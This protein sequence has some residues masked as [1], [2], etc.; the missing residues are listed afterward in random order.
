MKRLC[1]VW[2]CFLCVVLPA[3]QLP[4]Q[5]ELREAFANPPKSASPRVWW[6]WMNG[7]ISPEGIRKDL[8]WM[9]SAGVAGFHMF[10]AGLETP[11]VV[12]E[13]I[14]FMTPAW[15]EA[16]RLALHLADSL[17]MEVSVA[18]SPGWS[19][20]GGP[21][22]P[23]EESMKTLNWKTID[24][25]GG[26]RFKGALPEPDSVA[27]KYLNHVLNRHIPEQYRFYRD[28]YVIAVKVPD[29]DRPMEEL[30]VRITA[31]DGSDLHALHDG[32][33]MS[34]CTVQPDSTGRAWILFEFPER[35]TVKAIMQGF[36]DDW[37]NRRM[38]RWEY[39]DDGV[40]FHTLVEYS[41]NT[42][43]PFLT[44]SV[45]DTRAR[46][47]RVLSCQ[48][49][50]PLTHNEL[51]LYPFS[52]VNMDTEKAG[53]FTDAP[54]RDGFPTPTG[55][56]AV[57]LRDVLNITSNYRNGVLRWN[58]PS[59]RW[60]IYRVG[61]TLRGRRNGPA[62]P[63]ATGL[64]VD[65]MNPQAVAHYYQ[66]Y[67]GLLDEAGGGAMG[68]VVSNLMIDSYEAGCQTWTDAMPQEFERRRGYSMMPWMPALF[69]QVVES[70]GE[71]DR[72]LQ[73]WRQTI[74]EMMVEY[75]Y[76]A[77]DT[78]LA[79]YGMGRY[80]ES[81]EGGRHFVADGM[82][83][84]RH[85]EVPM[86]AFWVTDAY[87]IDPLYE[88][89]IRESASVA[90]ICGQNVCAAESF[91]T[92]GLGRYPDGRLRAWSFHPGNL[93]PHADAA[94]A[95]GLNRF[96][97]H[98]SPH[99]PSDSIVPGLS[100]GRFGQ[101]FDRHETWA[102]EAGLWTGYL[103][104]SCA[105]LSLG[106]FVADIAVY[107]GETNNLTARFQNERAAVPEG[108]AF[109]FV[110]K[111]MLLELLEPADSGLVTHSGMCYRALLV[112]SSVRF[113]SMPVLRRLALF[114]DAGLLL[115]ANPPAGCVNLKYDPHEFD[116]LVRAVWHSGRD[117]VVS[118]EM[119]D[120]AL[121]RRG[122][123][124]DVVF[125][126]DSTDGLRFVHRHLA[127]GELYWVTNTFP[128]AREVTV[129]FRVAGKRPLLLHAETGGMEEASYVIREGRT[130]VR[131]R[132]VP[133]DALFVW[134][135]EEA[136][137]DSL[138]VP[139]DVCRTV[140]ELTGGRWRIL[141]RNG[142]GAPDSLET[143]TLF[144]L[145]FSDEPAIHFFSG[146]VSYNMTFK[147]H[148]DGVGDSLLCLD[149]GEVCHLARV[150]LN[151]EDIGCCWKAPYRLL[152]SGRLREGNN[153]LEIRVTNTWANR[154]TGD[155]KPDAATGTTR[156][157]YP[158]F[159]PDLPLDRSGLIG[160]VRILSIP[161]HCKSRCFPT[162][163]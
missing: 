100:L 25:E 129:S 128:Q 35:Q 138:S 48:D 34:R 120:V 71:T 12:P 92:D 8:L 126:T 75:H 22:V 63:E 51:R 5:S 58:V 94:M 46:F 90:H 37:A 49:G 11:Q 133:D 96:V 64:E 127:D 24:V 60:R 28:L 30:G 56:D 141:F 32:D 132:F 131:L 41:P 157:S 149:L 42:H 74:G 136:N 139:Q 50:Q 81:H 9:H 44:F 137:T 140:Q 1:R 52:R 80:T 134:F 146:T 118:P 57:P 29:A 59:G 102:G 10:D 144:P 85:A 61:Y 125:R 104:R 103:S 4:A 2:I 119:L 76:D 150:F 105:M 19:A 62:S 20:T 113:V 148:D 87:G 53:F 147:W 18:S 68:K 38:R 135:G 158:Y 116:S 84:K 99:Q 73:D 67:F 21:W 79:R 26:R 39:S 93:K 108:Y 40:H 145:N 142:G 124:Q 122:S 156:T 112:D 115:A 54:L 78:L 14:A 45:P 98:C 3:F 91:T 83:V 143:D 154:L 47:F 27:G 110:N 6:H 121:H 95:C 160:P 72:F 43:I 89:D 130:L 77:V 15:N 153:T 155:S 69:G 152:L 86:S 66:N 55:S 7:N 31:S 16:F 117:N 111:S 161:P 159:T 162:S 109:D 163:R 88:A 107:Y 151:G 13:R 36:D 82:D 65:K 97:I 23:E 123:V 33:M 70:A 17:G 114:A 101:W 106:R